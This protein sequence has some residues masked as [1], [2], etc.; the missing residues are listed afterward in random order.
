[1]GAEGRGKQEAFR[2]HQSGK[3]VEGGQIIK[4]LGDEGD[5]NERRGNQRRQRKGKVETRASYL[6]LEI[7]SHHSRDQ[8]KDG[9][10]RG[11]GGTAR[12]PGGE[13]P[14]KITL[15]KGGH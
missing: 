8:G 2:A 9:C 6:Y 14:S 15:A 11:V 5:G 1:M 13:Q 10:S 3:W 4:V 7:H 12:K